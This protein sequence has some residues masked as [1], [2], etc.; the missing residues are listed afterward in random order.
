M[1]SVRAGRPRFYLSTV[2][3]GVNW[4]GRE[5]GNFSVSSSDIESYR[6]F[7]LREW[8][9]LEKKMYRFNRSN[10][11]SESPFCESYRSLKKKKKWEIWQA[12]W[13][14]LSLKIHLW[15]NSQSVHHFRRYILRYFQ[16]NLIE[17]SIQALY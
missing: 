16:K 17:T 14:L 9:K 12:I 6:S 3:E 2:I 5:T 11:L 15:Q 4:L 8:N 1:K 7:H 13:L 10:S